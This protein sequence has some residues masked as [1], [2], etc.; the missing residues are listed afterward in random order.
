MCEDRIDDIAKCSRHI[1]QCG[2]SLFNAMRRIQ[3][4]VAP[5]KER[6]AILNFIR[7]HGMSIAAASHNFTEY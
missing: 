2:T 4:D 3:E 5:S 1:Y 6:D 7:D